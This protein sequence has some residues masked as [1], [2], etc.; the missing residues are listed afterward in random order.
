[1]PTIVSNI[2]SHSSLS[3]GMIMMSSAEEP[4]LEVMF[5]IFFA[6]LFGWFIVF[7]VLE[8]SS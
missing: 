2:A 8:I 3:A 7:R 6:S 5:I 1:M 4:R